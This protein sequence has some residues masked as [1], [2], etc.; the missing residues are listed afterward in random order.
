M[1][2]GATEY[3]NKPI[4]SDELLKIVR[5]CLFSRANRRHIASPD[6]V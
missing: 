2:A 6:H 3:L 5:S 1:N 4:H